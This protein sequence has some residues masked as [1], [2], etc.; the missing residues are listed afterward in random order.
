MMYLKLIS[1]GLTT[2]YECT[3][4]DY[5]EDDDPVPHPV[6]ESDN[7]FF[8]DIRRLGA[9]GHFKFKKEL[10]LFIMNE[11]GNTIDSVEFV[12]HWD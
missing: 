12:P 2:F 4:L 1:G 5:R 11:Q 3:E 10:K 8:L 7:A 6:D 9:R